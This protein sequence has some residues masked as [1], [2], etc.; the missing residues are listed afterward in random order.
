[1]IPSIIRIICAG[2]AYVLALFIERKIYSI[3]CVLALFIYRTQDFV[4]EL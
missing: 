1:M 4:E 3:A 2:I